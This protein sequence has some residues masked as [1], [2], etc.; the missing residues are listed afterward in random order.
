MLQGENAFHKQI[1]DNRDGVNSFEPLQHTR[2]D[3]ERVADQE[4]GQ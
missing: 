1:P 2:H 4:I 3:Y